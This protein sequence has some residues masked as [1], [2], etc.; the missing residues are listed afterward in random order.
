MR[1]IQLSLVVMMLGTSVYARAQEPR[2]LNI[3]DDSA[4]KPAGWVPGDVSQTVVLP[5]EASRQSA[6]TDAPLVGDRH[7]RFAFE[8]CKAPVTSAYFCFRQARL[9]E[10]TACTSGT[11]SASSAQAFDETAAAH[12]TFSMHEDVR[13]F[14]V[15]RGGEQI[16][17]AS[18]PSPAAGGSGFFDGGTA[19][20]AMNPFDT[21][22]AGVLDGG[23]TA[24]SEQAPGSTPPVRPKAIS[25]S[26]G[27]YTRLKIHKYASFAVLPLFA[28]QSVIGEKLYNGT[29]SRSQRSIHQ[30]LA[31]GI[32]GLFGVNSVTGIWNLWDARKDPNGRTKRMLHGILM[33]TADAGFVAADA[34]AHGRSRTGLPLS[35]VNST[36]RAIAFTSI[37]VATAGYL[38]MLFGR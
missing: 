36:H 8:N 7:A 37:G 9:G 30:G 31:V 17:P 28:A 5:P 20:A 13:V 32:I 15:E 27:Y 1:S 4:S 25:Y 38:I 23:S 34:S 11:S 24:G 21:K 19:G 3:R 14:Q 2:T 6:M 35:S 10:A 29:A 26:D 12:A 33:L 22:T 16:V 18:M